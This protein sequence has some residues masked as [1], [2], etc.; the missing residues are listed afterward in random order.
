MGRPKRRSGGRVT[1]KKSRPRYD[2]DHSADFVRFDGDYLHETQIQAEPP[3]SRSATDFQLELLGRDA[4]HLIGKVSGA[5]GPDMDKADYW[6]SCI[7]T[8]IVTRRNPDG[9]A[10]SEVL[11]HARRTGGSE[12]AVLAAAVAVYGPLGTASKAHRALSS[13]REKCPEAPGWID[14]LGEAEPLR[15]TRTTDRWGERGA[16]CIDYRRPD[17]TEHGVSVTIQPFCLA[18]A[19][20]FSLGPPSTERT[21]ASPEDELVEDLSLADARAIVEAGLLV[22]DRLGQHEDE[23]DVSYEGADEDMRALLEQRLA[24]LPE[25]GRAPAVPPLDADAA[26]GCIADFLKHGLRLGEHPDEIH[27]LGRTMLAFAMMCHDRDILHWTPPRA[28]S[29]L[30]DWL[31]DHG[32]FCEECGE[33]HEHP[34]YEEW[35]STVESVFPRWLR[36]A[37][38]RRNLPDEALEANLTAARESLKQMRLHATG[39]PVRLS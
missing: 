16:V 31:A 19:H 15:A 30:E 14:L 6:A 3:R 27:D 10:A 18:M 4:V 36:Y 17:G 25:G 34:P 39:S 24:L 37:A 38:E 13:I 7:Q 8:A 5:D 21:A 23:D 28:A 32:L 20:D 11:A 29:F 33:S 9:V 2:D 35:L 12:G 1:P 22:N 26:A